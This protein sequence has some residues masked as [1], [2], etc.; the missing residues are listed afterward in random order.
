MSFFQEKPMRRMKANLS[1]SEKDKYLGVLLKLQAEG[2]AIEIPEE[3]SQT[4]DVLRIEVDADWRNEVLDVGIIGGV[5]YYAVRFRMIAERPEL[6]L[7]DY[8]ITTDW[9][10]QIGLLDMELPDHLQLL[11]WFDCQQKEILNSRFENS[12]RFRRRGQV[13]EGWI[14][15]A[16]SRPIPP[17]YRSGAN[18]P[19]KL[20]FWDQFEH[21]IGVQADLFVRRLKQKTAALPP[22]TGLDELA[23][24]PT[25]SVAEESRLR[26]LCSIAREKEAKTGGKNGT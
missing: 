15:A 19:C 21:K 11:R 18:V 8:E 10:D 20:T 16:G 26:Y 4:A 6:T 23:E 3:V 17:E 13:I 14:V 2:H 24:E 7:L 9:D 22:R 25:L 1:R 12:L 5:G